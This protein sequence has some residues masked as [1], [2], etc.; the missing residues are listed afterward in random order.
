MMMRS[1]TVAASGENNLNYLCAVGGIEER[2]IRTH[3]LPGSI[4]ADGRLLI[5]DKRNHQKNSVR[6]NFSV[7]PLPVAT[8][9][10]V[11]YTIIH[12]EDVG[13]T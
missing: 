11:S 12:S 1:L 6:R 10:K 3:L 4:C 13:G 7:S 2:L 9:H 8:L 5:L